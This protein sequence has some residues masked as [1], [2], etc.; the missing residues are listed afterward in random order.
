MTDLA[1]R[2]GHRLLP[3]PRRVIAKLFVPGEETR[4]GNSRANAVVARILALPEPE[5]SA[6]ADAV[7]AEFGDRH[8]DLTGILAR[9][10]DVVAHEVPADRTLSAHRRTAIGAY[11][12]HEYAP[13]AAALFNPSMTAHPDQTGLAVGQSRFVMTVRCVG[14]GHLSSIGF[15]TGVLGPGS[16]VVVDDPEPVLATGSTIPGPY[17]RQAFLSRLADVGVEPQN[18]QMLLGALPES[19]SA[20]EL[21]TALTSVHEHTLGRQRVKRAIAQVMQIAYATYAVQF[22]GAPGLTGRLLWPSAPAERN[23]MED[24]RLVRFANGD[25]TITYYAPFTAYDGSRVA[26]HLLSTQDF[27]QFQVAPLAGQAARNKGLSL[28]PRLIGGRYAALSRWDRENLSL[29]YSDDGQVWEESTILHRPVRGWELI[30]VGNGG[31]PIETP[32]GWLVLTHGV[33]PM[34]QY[35]LGAMLLDLNE[36]SRVVA[37]LTRPL[38]TPRGDERDA[39]VP[40]VVYTCGAMLHDGLVTIPYGISDGAIGFAQV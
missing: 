2:T 17:R 1:M 8:P 5:V 19:F 25:G 29:A 38:L 33:G 18:A 26:T 24:A 31:P 14:E 6:L 20:E 21:N 34:R 40:N 27:W 10:F 36:P 39:Y 3:D 23:G 12:T 35:A 37:A 30:Q 16:S 28:F 22:P 7:V 11:F 4:D 13:E 32:D 15:R 9:H